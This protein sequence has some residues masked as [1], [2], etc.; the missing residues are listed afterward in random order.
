MVPYLKYIDPEERERFS[1][2]ATN[3]Q[4][5]ELLLENLS[6][7]LTVA[8]PAYGKAITPVISAAA[9]RLL[10]KDIYKTSHQRNIASS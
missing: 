2:L 5:R 10:A 3:E 4:T 7:V 9:E 1:K 8:L 6:A